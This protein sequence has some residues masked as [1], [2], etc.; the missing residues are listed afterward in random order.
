M[1]HW[2][3]RPEPRVTGTITTLRAV[4]GTEVLNAL[5]LTEE[6]TYNASSYSGKITFHKLAT[7]V[8]DSSTV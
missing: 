5:P 2:D 1:A 3:T 7:A 8:R 6:E 4:Q